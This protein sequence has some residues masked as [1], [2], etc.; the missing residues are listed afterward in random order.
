M[1]LLFTLIL[2]LAPL[3]YQSDDDID[4][5]IPPLSVFQLTNQDHLRFRRG[6]INNT[7]EFEFWRIYS[8]F[9]GLEKAFHLEVSRR[10]RYL[11]WQRVLKGS[12][13][14][15]PLLAQY[16]KAL[17]HVIET[18]TIFI[19]SHMS[20]SP[21]E[22]EDLKTVM[23]YADAII[24]KRKERLKDFRVHTLLYHKHKN[25]IDLWEQIAGVLKKSFE[26]Q[27]VFAN[28]FKEEER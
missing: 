15:G 10:P 28:R 4:L 5:D 11:Y 9:N 17:K 2:I 7:D 14:P 1:I 21:F 12:N 22:T 18:F 24:L 13:W 16:L 23:K 27:N 25:I 20:A 19:N 6:L 8:K 26:L 3:S